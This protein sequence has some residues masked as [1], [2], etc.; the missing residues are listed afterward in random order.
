MPVIRGR[1]LEEEQDANTRK[2]ATGK[3]NRMEPSQIQVLVLDS[4]GRRHGLPK[5]GRGAAELPQYTLTVLISRRRK[6]R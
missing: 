6:H 1:R 5:R 4:I 2:Q 3:G